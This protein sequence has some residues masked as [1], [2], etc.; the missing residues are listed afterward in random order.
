MKMQSRLLCTLPFVIL[1]VLF[2]ISGCAPYADLTPG[3]KR[4]ILSPIVSREEVAV[5][6]LPAESPPPK[7]YQVGAGDV[8]LLDV[9][10]RPEFTIAV[11]AGAGTGAGA[12]AGAGPVGVG[13]KVQG[14]RVDGAGM[15][16]VPLVGPVQVAGLTLTQVEAKLTTLLKKYLQDPWVVAEV[17]DYKSLPLYLLGQFRVSG[18]FYMDRPMT[19]LQGLSLGSGFD[20]S[21]NLKGARLTRDGKIMPVNFNDLLIKGETSQN[22]WLKGGDTIYIPDNRNQVVFIFG[23]VK[24][25]GLVPMPPGGLNL[26][27]AIASAELRDAGFDFHHVRIIRSLSATRGELM[28]VDYEMVLRGEALPMQL[29]EG[30]I[31]YVPKS[32]FGTW[33]DVIADIL[34]S[35]QT[36]GGILQPFVSMKYLM[37]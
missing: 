35:L 26:A 27:Q 2:A 33:N 29:A 22:I 18:T 31:V 5:P 17:L 23:A 36:V 7:N 25:P 34:P 13:G 3:T 10:G 16:H 8:L 14:S 4:E 32:G 11:Q 24:K 1:L 28:V 15:L 37:Q 6:A 19:L 20:P 21:A 30:D 12:G 9:S